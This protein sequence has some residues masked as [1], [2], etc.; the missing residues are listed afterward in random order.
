VGNDAWG[1]II[2]D[3]LGEFQH[4]DMSGVQIVPTMPTGV[5]AAL[6]DASGSRAFVSCAGAAGSVDAA[7]LDRRAE[8]LLRAPYLLICGYFF[9]PHLRGATL[10]A[11]LRRARQRGATTMLDTGWDSDNWPAASRREVLALLSEVDVFL[12]NLD[13]AEALTG[14]DTPLGCARALVASGA[15]AVAVKLGAEGSLWFDGKEPVVRPA[16]LVA[17]WDTT[18][19]GDAFNAALIYGMQRG[20]EIHQSLEFANGFCSLLVSRRDDRF[21]SPNDVF[22]ILSWKAA[23]SDPQSPA[24][25]EQRSCL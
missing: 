15:G 19:A 18:G 1:N 7:Y 16:R 23:E 10:H 13:E 17:A 14:A 25:F 20:W 4:I 22:D 21:P 5:C 6:V 8:C 9:M 12:P 11:F 2:R 24:T 3:T